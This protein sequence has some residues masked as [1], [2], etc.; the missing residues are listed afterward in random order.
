MNKPWNEWTYTFVQIAPAVPCQARE[1]HGVGEHVTTYGLL[2]QG[3]PG[4]GYIKPICES[5]VKVAI[6]RNVS[7][8]PYLR[9]CAAIVQAD[10]A[11]TKSER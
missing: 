4:G 10:A 2:G 11:S 9:G 7:I 6:Q 1:Q 8:E 5:C 3:M